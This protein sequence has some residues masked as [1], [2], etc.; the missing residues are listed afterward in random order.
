VS[1]QSWRTEQWAQGFV[2]LEQLDLDL[3]LG[4]KGG[5]FCGAL[6]ALVVSLP[7]LLGHGGVVVVRLGLNALAGVTKKSAIADGQNR[8]GRDRLAPTRRV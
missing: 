1:I 6:A 7:L 8:L 2:V 5:L 4:R 3:G